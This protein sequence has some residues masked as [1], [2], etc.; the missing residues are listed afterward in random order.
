MNERCGCRRLAAVLIVSAVLCGAAIVSLGFPPEKPY[1][2]RPLMAELEKRTTTDHFT[3]AVFGDAECHPGFDGVIARAEALKPDFALVMGDMVTVGDNPAHYDKLEKQFGPF[4]RKYPCWP[5]YGNHEAKKHGMGNYRKFYGMESAYYTF[6]FRN[7]RF[8][9]LQMP[10][11]PDIDRGQAAWLEKQLAE[12]KQAGKLLFVRQHAPCYSIGARDRIHLRNRPNSITTLCVK[13]GVVANFAGHDHIYY[14]TNR[15]GVWY[16]VQACGGCWVYP[17]RRE[18]EAVE[19]DVY[20]GG[21]PKPGSQY[22]SL[23]FKLHTPKGEK[24]YKQ[25]K[26]MLTL[27]EV[28]GTKV[29]GKTVAADGEVFDEFTLAEGKRAGQ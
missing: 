17:L 21:I 8:I 13:Y 2:P 5:C 27:I 12:G 25:P 1:D 10:D 29:T 9:T 23:S 24:P 19:G 3:F 4:M 20:F 6:D 26:Y 22:G 18:G 28:D 11:G 7:C 16:I 15:D 14:R